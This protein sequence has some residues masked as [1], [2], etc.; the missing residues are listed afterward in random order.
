MA[1]RRYKGALKAAGRGGLLAG[2]DEDGLGVFLI[3]DVG[4]DAGDGDTPG[5]VVMR[6]GL[7]A[8][9]P[10]RP[11]AMLDPIGEAALASMAER[12]VVRVHRRADRAL[13]YRA[14]API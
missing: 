4:E 6:R 11:V 10:Q 2:V 9:P 7:F 8:Q 12:L 1:H 3:G 14:W 5:G 13:R